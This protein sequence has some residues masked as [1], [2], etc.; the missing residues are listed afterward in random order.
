MD[1]FQDLFQKII[2]VIASLVITFTSVFTDQKPIATST[3]SPIPE[4]QV[5]ASATP[6]AKPLSKPTPSIKP[7]KT[8]AEVKLEQ[9]SKELEEIKKSNEEAKKQSDRDAVCKK[10]DDLSEGLPSGMP[11]KH[12]Y[13]PSD[14]SIKGYLDFYKDQAQQEYSRNLP[15]DNKFG[16]WIKSDGTSGSTADEIKNAVS[17]LEQKYNEYLESK[18]S[19]NTN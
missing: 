11:V 19:C 13:N 8:E 5:E 1:L 9:V 6:S 14:K 18:N 16:N 15:A 3:P 10:A 2:M 4:Q 12:I 17:Y 7:V